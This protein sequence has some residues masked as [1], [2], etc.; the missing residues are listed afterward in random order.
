MRHRAFLAGAVVA[1]LPLAAE[2]A[3]YREFGK[4]SVGCD[5]SL[6]CSAFGISDKDR[7]GERWG[8]RIDRA[9]GYEGKIRLRFNGKDI[10]DEEHIL[11]DGKMAMIESPAS[12][13]AASLPQEPLLGVVNRL[14][15][16]ATMTVP[17]EEKDGEVISLTGL[18]AALLY[19]D[20]RQG[21]IGSLNAFVAK[22]DKKVATPPRAYPIIKATKVPK[23]ES[24]AGVTISAKVSTAVMAHYRATTNRKICDV[25]VEPTSRETP[26]A[27]P[28]GKG[29]LLMEVSCWRAAYQAG[30]VFYLYDSARGTLRDA[31]F[32][33]LD[34]KTGALR[35]GKNDSVSGADVGDGGISGLHKGRGVGGCGESLGW[36]W[37]GKAFR[38]TSQALKMLCN[39]SDAAFR[40]YRAQIRDADGKLTPLGEDADEDMTF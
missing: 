21:R 28:L 29:L 30:S 9:P 15:N 12:M 13:G 4:W 8:L 11:I 35:I 18:K 27:Y 25:G 37:D 10:S 39:H 38:L 5:N 1:F 40:L 17:G 31:P 14:L 23:S 2:A 26:T 32:E 22:G 16:A 24:A 34:I 20:E 3:G 6:A 19:M 33:T 36:Q 7:G